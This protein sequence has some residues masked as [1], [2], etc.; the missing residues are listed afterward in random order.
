[1]EN[2]FLWSVVSPTIEIMSTCSK[3]YNVPLVF[4][5]FCYYMTVYLWLIRVK[6]SVLPKF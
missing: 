1:M 4:G 6:T 2:N 5:T 3:L